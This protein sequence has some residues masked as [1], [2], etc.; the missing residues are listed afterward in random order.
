MLEAMHRPRFALRM[1]LA[2]LALLAGPAPLVAQ[3]AGDL[4]ALKLFGGGFAPGTY[5]V[6]VPGVRDA[7]AT[8]CL[9]DPAPLLF[10]GPPLAPGCRISLIG[11]EPDRASLSWSCPGGDSGRTDLRRLHAGLFV[12]Q[13]QGVREG[14]PW[15]V[16]RQFQHVG[17]CGR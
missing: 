17:P 12:A 10:G 14:H 16:S 4:A 15:S 9:A 3:A 2:G 1:A 13:S 7:P 6:S 8:S 5:A 11:N